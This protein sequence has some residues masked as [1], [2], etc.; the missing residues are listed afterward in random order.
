LVYFE[1]DYSC[2]INL[3]LEAKYTLCAG[4]GDLA[5]GSAEA[6]DSAVRAL[7]RPSKK[8]DWWSLSVGLGADDA[9]VTSHYPS[10]P[11]IKEWPL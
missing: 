4:Q 9:L 6:A 8:K 11:S 3:G 1:L 10:L 5:L 7:V 2:N